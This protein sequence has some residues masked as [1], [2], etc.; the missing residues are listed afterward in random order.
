MSECLSFSTYLQGSSS[1]Y[2]RTLKLA[3][4]LVTLDWNPD[5]YAQLGANYWT[6]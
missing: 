3:V 6:F 1:C 4:E 5:T 2:Q